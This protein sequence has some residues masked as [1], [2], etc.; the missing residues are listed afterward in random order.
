MAAG[1]IIIDLLMKTGSFE[2][3]TQRAAK[4]AEKRAREIQKS[5]EAAGESI[6]TAFTGIFAGLTFGAA[7]AGFRAITDQLDALNDVADAT[8][9]SIENISALEDIG[10]RTGAG[11]ETVEAAMVKLNQALNTAADPNSG[12]AGAL[13]AIGLSAKELTAL[14][15]AQALLK[16]AQALDVYADD[17]NKARLMQ[18]LLGKSMKELAPF[19]KDL[20]EAGQ[21]NATVTSDQA[22]QAEKFN[23][24]LFEMQTNVQG[25]ARS[26]AMVFIPVLTDLSKHITEAQ[27]Q[28]GGFLGLISGGVTGMGRALA[29]LPVDPLAIA[30][31]KYNALIRERVGI[32]KEAAA[33]DK[34]MREGPVDNRY[35]MELGAEKRHAREAKRLAEVD[36]QIQVASAE[37]ERLQAGA[38]SASGEE[39]KK[40]QLDFNPYTPPKAPKG[41]KPP[42]EYDAELE[43]SRRAAEAYAATLGKLADAQE[44][45]NDA[46]LDLT[47]SQ[48][49]LRD[50]MADPVWQ[51]MPE[52]WR[53]LAISQTEAAAAAEKIAADQKRLNDLIAATP[54]AQLEKQREEMQFL[55]DAFEKGLINAE[56]FGE[57][58]MTALGQLQT[59]TEEATDSMTVFADQAARNMQDA[60]ANF[61]FDP[62]NDGLDGMLRG[63]AQTL[64]RMASQMLAAKVFEMIGG[65]LKGS[66]TGW[67]ASLGASLLKSVSGAR[68]DGGPVSAGKT[69]LVGERGPELFTPNTA[70]RVL[71]N[72]L[73]GQGAA[74][75]PVVNIRNVNAFDTQMIGDYMGSDAGERVII[76]AVKR[77]PGLIRQLAA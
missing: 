20:A 3:D 61:L 31:E 32:M 21:L 17:G 27:R 38:G 69:Y 74:A 72:H 63:F 52:S 48:R 68:A 60:F 57:A 35:A 53:Q 64:Q 42:K 76:N 18:E 44:A 11:L 8:G 40:P 45:A 12:A 13:E 26:F 39:Q 56:Q 34:A 4:L 49:A 65:V 28:Y 15:P 77:N 7:V 25:A 9:A 33:A 50:L 43:M 58:A 47:P 24:Q 62:F 19:L 29:G 67:I 71:P 5:F 73:M 14:D 46:T 54:T 6:K 66:D 16:V 55:A 59:K 70:G 1:S 37:L 30:Q 10:R 36:A 22:A 75:A 51:S 23:K 41:P 2:T